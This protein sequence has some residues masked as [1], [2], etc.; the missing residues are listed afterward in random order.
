MD[1]D[2]KIMVT[3]LLEE[4]DNATTG[5]DD[6]LMNYHLSSWFTSGRFEDREE[7]EQVS[8]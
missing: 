5:I 1:S 7:E 2:D 3:T 4:K 6:R 8:S